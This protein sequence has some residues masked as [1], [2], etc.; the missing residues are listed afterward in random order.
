METIEFNSKGGRL[1]I[2]PAEIIDSQKGKDV[3][4]RLKESSI[5][6]NIKKEASQSNGKQN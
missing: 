2:N 4:N 6:K 3:I 5:Y 1:F